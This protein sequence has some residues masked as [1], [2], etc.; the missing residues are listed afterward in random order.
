MATWLS[1]P[2]QPATPAA[3][4]PTGNE[5][6]RVRPFSNQGVSI[7]I[8]GGGQRAVACDNF[9]LASFLHRAEKS[10]SSAGREGSA[11]AS[12]SKRID[13]AA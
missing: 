11:E 6:E 2:R 12:L 3:E 5:S 13:L 8:K 1:A 10:L 7:L 4:D 9:S